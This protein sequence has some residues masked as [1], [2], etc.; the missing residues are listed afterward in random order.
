[1]IEQAQATCVFKDKGKSKV[2]KKAISEQ[3]TKE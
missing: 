2:L 1:M 3:M